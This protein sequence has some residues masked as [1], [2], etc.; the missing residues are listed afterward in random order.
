MNRFRNSSPVE[1]FPR[2]IFLFTLAVLV[3][4][5]VPVA[6]QAQIVF[7]ATGTNTAAITPTRDSFRT[8]LGG[9]TVAGANGSFGGVRRE[10]NWDGVPANFAAPNALPPN[11]FNVNSP[12]GVLFSTPGSGL[13]VSGAS[14]DA[15]A[16]Q[17]VLQFAN[18]DPSYPTVFEPFSPERLFTAIG[19]NTVDVTFFLAGTTTPA[20][21]TGFGS[22][23]SDVDLANTTSITYF[24]AAN[25]SLGTFF[26]PA[27]PGSQTYS[28]LGVT[29]STAIV[30]RVR[31]VSGNAALAAGVQESPTIDLVTM[32]D[33]IYGE[34]RLT[35][36]AAHVQVSGRVL[37]RDGA[38]LRNAIVTLT[39][40]EG[41]V[42]TARTGAFG[43]YSFVDVEVGTYIAGVN[44]KTFAYT[45]R[46]VDVK[47]QISGLDFYPSQ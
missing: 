16:G 26:V 33:F 2:R 1:I 12:R 24:D 34:P 47:D 7:S 10:I 30:A 4:V 36:T 41:R 6:A 20:R 39:D 32:D 18:I 17:P 44:S 45:A 9:G 25:N 43:Y 42:M 19:S 21:V 38:G 46:V 3:L 8:A 29:F 31:I 40:A 15:G 22:V 35:T 28:F 13:Q 37:T 27:T 5:V 11:F 14:S 23:F